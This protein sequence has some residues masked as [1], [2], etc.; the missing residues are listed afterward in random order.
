[1]KITFNGIE[2][3]PACCRINRKIYWFAKLPV[4]WI[5]WKTNSHLVAGITLNRT[6][7]LLGVLTQPNYDR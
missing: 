6:T 4:D 7:Y 3:A 5:D 1:M 2:L